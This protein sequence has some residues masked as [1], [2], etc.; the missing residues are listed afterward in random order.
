MSLQRIIEIPLQDIQSVNYEKNI[1]QFGDDSNS[2]ICCGKRI[3]N[4]PNCKFI[5]LLTNGNIVSYSG[6]DIEDSQGFFPIGNDCAKK[7]VIKFTF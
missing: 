4:Y 7:L 2:C 1:E 3:K 6:D 5:H